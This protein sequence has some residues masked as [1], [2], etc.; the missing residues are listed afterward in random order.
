MKKAIAP[1]QYPPH[2]RPISALLD[3]TWL[4]LIW[5]IQ[6]EVNSAPFYQYHSSKAQSSWQL[7]KSTATTAAS[8]GWKNTFGYRQTLQSP[9]LSF[10]IGEVWWMKLW[11][12]LP[13]VIVGSVSVN[14]HVWGGEGVSGEV[15]V[16]RLRERAKYLGFG[17]FLPGKIIPCSQIV[18]G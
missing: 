9:N 13:V 14:Y 17:S 7:Q 6:G 18:P 1:L 12:M 4:V 15:F 10:G 5:A 16:S 8:F 2:F 3:S 11:G